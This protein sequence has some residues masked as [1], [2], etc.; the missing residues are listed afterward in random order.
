MADNDLKR[1]GSITGSPESD[2]VGF[3]LP[4]SAPGR[5]M[6]AFLTDG[7]D[8]PGTTN[9]TDQE[10]YETE[11]DEYEPESYDF[12]PSQDAEF[13]LT[14]AGYSDPEIQLMKGW[15]EAGHSP[16]E[17]VA[18][19]Q[20]LRERDERVYAEFD[21]R[22]AGRVE[23]EAFERQWGE[24]QERNEILDQRIQEEEIEQAR[25]I[26]EGIVKKAGVQPDHFDDVYATAN[27]E[28]NARYEDRIVA[29]Y[30]PEEADELGRQEARA[31]LQ[32]HAERA[33]EVQLHE[34]IIRNTTSVRGAPDSGFMSDETMQLLLA[35]GHRPDR[36]A[37]GMKI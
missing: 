21:Q 22:V 20:T 8:D 9:A 19:I 12:D 18:G 27:D 6:D 31:L 28:A 1:D 3:H 23:D 29:G 5:R 26:F 11:P 17:I 10:D 16:D 33:R 4:D 32:A 37:R 7:S 13:Q 15:A 25:P 14:Q 34:R 36:I 30:S 24:I 2:I 35:N